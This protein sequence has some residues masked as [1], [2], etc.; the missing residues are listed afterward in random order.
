M[1]ECTDRD[2]TALDAATVED[3]YRLTQRCWQ[4]TTVCNSGA[5]AM[6]FLALVVQRWK[7]A[8]VW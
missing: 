7:R 2:R 4:C 5:R 1:D 3:V 6:F 8:A